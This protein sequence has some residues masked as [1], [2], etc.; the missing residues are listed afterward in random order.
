MALNCLLVALL[1]GADSL[2]FLEA[3]DELSLCALWKPLQLVVIDPRCQ[4]PLISLRGSTEVDEVR[5]LVVGDGSTLLL[6]HDT[7][8][9]CPWQPQLWSRYGLCIPYCTHCYG[10]GCGHNGAYSTVAPTPLLL[11]FHP[12]YRAMILQHSW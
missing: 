12:L 3:L 1:F 6:L 7:V 11:W 5:S 9:L 8:S 4:P 2:S 10:L